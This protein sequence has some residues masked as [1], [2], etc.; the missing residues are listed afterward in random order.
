MVLSFVPPVQPRLQETSLNRFGVDTFYH[1]TIGLIVRCWTACF[2]HGRCQPLK[3]CLA[4]WAVQL[5]RLLVYCLFIVE[6]TALCELYVTGWPVVTD[7]CVTWISTNQ[8]VCNLLCNP[9]LYSDLCLVFRSRRA[10][11]SNKCLERNW[12]LPESFAD[13]LLAILNGPQYHLV[14]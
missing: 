10:W 7:A 1:I 2:K 5:S 8:I 12:S 14:I 3:F 6:L 4:G 13:P 11:S 9:V